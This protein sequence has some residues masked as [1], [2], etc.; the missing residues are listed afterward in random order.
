ML[1][2]NDNLITFL[3]EGFC[4]SEKTKIFCVQLKVINQNG[5]L[6]C[7]YNPHKHLIKTICYKLKVELILIL[8]LMKILY[9]QVTLTLRFL[10]NIWTLPVLFSI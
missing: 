8:N 2:V 1:F 7:C 3:V 6:F 9:Y 4:F 10:Q 5:L